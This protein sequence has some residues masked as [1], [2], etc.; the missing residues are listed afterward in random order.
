[1]YSWFLYNFLINVQLSVYNFIHWDGIF[2][3][4]ESQCMEFLC[5]AVATFIDSHFPHSQFTL[6][7]NYFLWYVTP[8]ILIM[9]NCFRENVSDIVLYKLHTYTGCFTIFAILTYKYSTIWLYQD[10]YGA[11]IIYNEPKT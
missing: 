1:M 5:V 6:I 3:Q 2:S 10:V 7:P 4:G 9:L 8:V 11:I